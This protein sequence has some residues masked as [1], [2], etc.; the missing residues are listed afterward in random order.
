M[1][2]TKQKKLKVEIYTIS[3]TKQGEKKY[4]ELKIP[5]LAKKITGIQITSRLIS[6]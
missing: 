3:I 1:D 4:F 6:F 2:A 5:K